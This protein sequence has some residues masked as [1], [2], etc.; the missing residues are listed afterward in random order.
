MS[1]F[2]S[3]LLLT[4]ALFRNDDECYFP[5]SPIKQPFAPKCVTTITKGPRHRKPWHLISDA[6]RMQFVNGYQQ[7]R[8][9]GVLSTFCTTH[10]LEG[11]AFEDI[12]KTSEFFF[13]HSYFGTLC[14]IHL[15]TSSQNN[16]EQ[17]GNL[18]LNLEI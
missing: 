8:R 1:S 17:C 16:S 4:Q 18:R 15:H 5:F 6:E 10:H 14:I 13:W 2:F 12:H 9:N 7:L 11:I 3:S